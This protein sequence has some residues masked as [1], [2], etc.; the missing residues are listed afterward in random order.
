M[1]AR[2]RQGARSTG[3]R[4]LALPVALVV[5][6]AAG[7]NAFGGLPYQLDEQ[8]NVQDAVAVVDRFMAAGESGD[9]SAAEALVAD[10]SDDPQLRPDGISSLFEASRELFDGYA[11]VDREPYGIGFRTTP[12]GTRAR[13]GGDVSFDGRS[14]T[15]F[16]AELV[17]RNN[18]WQLT[19]LS[20]E[21]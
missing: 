7:W 14:A 11:A 19:A 20:F 17:K 2:T 1:H 13:L 8:Q 15:P 6:G 3:I 4:W 12:L 10:S 21:P 18:A 5:V 16:E 9:A